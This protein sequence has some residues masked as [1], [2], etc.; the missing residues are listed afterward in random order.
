MIAA[1]RAAHPELSVRRL[2]GL[3]GVNRAWYY[4]QQREDLAVA[5]EATRLRDTIERLVLAFP[6]Y[7]YRRVTKALQRDGWGV[8]HQRVLRVMRQESCPKAKFWFSPA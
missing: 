7:G 2:C 4:Q 3:L 6:G 1:A 8:N 5:A